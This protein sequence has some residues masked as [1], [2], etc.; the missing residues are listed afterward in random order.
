[1]LCLAGIRRGVSQQVGATSAQPGDKEEIWDWIGA[2]RGVT[3]ETGMATA[4]HWL[5]HLPLSRP[6]LGLAPP[7]PLLSC[8]MCAMTYIREHHEGHSTETQCKDALFT[9][10]STQD[11]ALSILHLMV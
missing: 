2:A 5:S 1:M 8:K 7:T 10:S 4:L 9:M 11:P 3:F 6:G